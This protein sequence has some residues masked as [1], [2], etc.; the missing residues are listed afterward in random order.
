MSE[1]DRKARQLLGNTQRIS[2]TGNLDRNTLHVLYLLLKERSVTRT[3]MMVGLSQPAVSDILSRLRVLTGDQLLVRTGSKL[4][5]TEHARGLAPHVERALVELDWIGGKKV[6]FSPASTT[7]TFRLGTADNLDVRFH[8][9]LVARLRQEAPQARLETFALTRD[10]DYARELAEGTVDVVVANWPNPPGQL[11]LRPLLET[12]IVFITGSRNRWAKGEIGWEEYQQM[13]HIDIT[14]RAL[15]EVSPIDV[16]LVRLGVRRNI[17]AHYP[18]FSLIPAIVA[19]TDLVFTGGRQFLQ[20]FVGSNDL[21]LRQLPAAL[22]PLQFYQL[23]HE[24]SHHA[25]DCA[26]LRKVMAEV[27]ARLHQD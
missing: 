24:R 8:V 21:V 19:S 25:D 22:A 20:G 5:L 17:V 16:N 11:R 12:E 14:P 9:N 15:G 3:A 7:R 2:K 26:W 4:E 13:A 6:E 23:W 18:F 10:F 1:L 27:A